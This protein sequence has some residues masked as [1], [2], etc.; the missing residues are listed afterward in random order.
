MWRC[1]QTVVRAAAP[2]AFGGTALCAAAAGTA[3][4]P[5]HTTFPHGLTGRGATH[6]FYTTQ[7]DL[8]AP[9]LLRGSGDFMAAARADARERL[10]LG[11]AAAVLS[12]QQRSALEE[13]VRQH[14]ASAAAACS[15]FLR[16]GVMHDREEIT[17]AL[18]NGVFRRQGQLALLLGGKSVGKSSLLAALAKRDDIVGSDGAVRAVLYVDARQFSTNLAAGLQAALLGESRELQVSG[19]WE[20][21]GAAGMS[22]RRPQQARPAPLEASAPVS[23]ISLATILRDIGLEA[24]VHFGGKGTVMEANME[25]L[26]KVVELAEAQGLYICLVID[27]ANLALPTPPAQQQ[28]QQQPL[29]PDERRVLSDTR[30]LLERLVQ[31]TKQ[32]NRMNALIVTSE[33]SFPYRLQHDNFFNTSNLTRTLFAGEV[34]PADMRALLRA[35]GLGPRLCDVFLA[36]YGG[37]VHL[38][39]QALAL[40]EEQQDLFRCDAVAPLGVR[41]ALGTCLQESRGPEMAAMLR[42]MAAQGFAP[43]SSVGDACAQALSQASVGGLVVTSAT[44]VGLPEGLRE[45]ARFGC[46]PSSNFS[47]RGRLSPPPASGKPW[48]RA[49]SPPP[50]SHAH[51]RA[52]HH[53]CFAAPPN[54]RGAPRTGARGGAGLIFSSVAVRE[55]RGPAA[56]ALRQCINVQILTQTPSRVRGVPPAACVP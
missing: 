29:P 34:P 51:T 1:V 3:D 55:D 53:A 30:L 36:F 18:V 44:V 39:A 25:M 38:A 6:R 17:A 11:A 41:S 4:E 43:V 9:L 23:S 24:K 8:G 50:S 14:L 42:A 37:H 28:Q 26:V 35:W 2:L 5:L 56:H 32:S 33:Y 52:P 13:G 45:G 15:A 16:S 20:W 47:V 31:L 22:R 46:V 19:W 27:E 48:R 12:E 21:L 54:C 7:L 40:L 49:S 10:G